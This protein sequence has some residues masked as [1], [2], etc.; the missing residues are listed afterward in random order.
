MPLFPP[1]MKWATH[2]RPSVF[3]DKSRYAAIIPG[4][5]SRIMHLACANNKQFINNF[6]MVSL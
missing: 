4:Y 3:Q 5:R 6:K 2:L 1:E